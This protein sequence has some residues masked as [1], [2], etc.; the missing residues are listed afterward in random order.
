MPNFHMS[1]DEASKLV[2]LLRGQERA[3]SS[4]TNT[5]TPPRRATWPRSNKRIPK[6]LDDA[7]KIVTDGNY[8]VK[9]HSVGDYQ[10]ERRDPDARARIWT[11]VYR[12][13]RPDYV[14]RWIANPRAHLAVHRHAGE[15]TV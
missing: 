1:S 12:R 8:C 7:M 15:H 6:L 13:L 4:R 5:T 14:R 2:E 9:C 10:V 11:Q 3:R